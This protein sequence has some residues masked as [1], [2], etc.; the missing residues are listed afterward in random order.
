MTD[1]PTT[2][3]ENTTEEAVVLPRIFKIGSTRI[4]ED[5]SMRDMT[6]EQVQEML[7]FSH[8]EVANAKISTTEKDGSLFVEFIPKAGRK[9]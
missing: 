5:D 8:P 2:T 7:A 4:V 1:Q 3:N 9:G 6:N